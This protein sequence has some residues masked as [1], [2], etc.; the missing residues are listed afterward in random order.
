MIHL[1]AIRI[2][3]SAC[4]TVADE[5]VNTFIRLIIN[6]TTFAEPIDMLYTLTHLILL[7]SVC[8]KELYIKLFHD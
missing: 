1:C 3:T 6:R 5:Y 2:P 7:R 8:I 4:L